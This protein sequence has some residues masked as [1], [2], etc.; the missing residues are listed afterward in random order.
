MN[1][2][3]SFHSA[4]KG[5]DPQKENLKLPP[6]SMIYNQLLWNCYLQERIRYWILFENCLF[7]LFGCLIVGGQ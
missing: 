1:E 3:I 5:R 6:Q 7:L 2:K 4:F